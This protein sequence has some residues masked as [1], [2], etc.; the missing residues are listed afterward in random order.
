MNLPI[1]LKNPRKVLINIKNKDQKCFLC[2]HVRH[3]NP[4]KEH[5]ERIRKI[6]KKIVSNL[7][8]DGIEFPEQE[9][10]FDKIEVKNNIC[11]NM[12]GYEN[13][14]V[15]SNLRFRSWICCF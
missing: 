15:F 11:I 3:I 9:K 1:E 4:S 10:D 12:F 14:L 6:D 5:P 7:N 13:G 2:C 8:Y